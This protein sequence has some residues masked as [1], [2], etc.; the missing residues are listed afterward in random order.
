MSHPKSTIADGTRA[1]K[2]DRHISAARRSF[3]HGEMHL[4]DP[5][6]LNLCQRFE[7]MIMRATLFFCDLDPFLIYKGNYKYA[8]Q[9][10]YNFHLRS[11][12]RLKPTYSDKVRG[13]LR[14]P[15]QL[16]LCY[17]TI[18]F[19]AVC[20]IQTISCILIKRL[21]NHNKLSNTFQAN[22]TEI[23]AM[24]STADSYKMSIEQVNELGSILGNPY[25]ILVEASLLFQTTLSIAIFHGFIMIPHNFRIIPMDAPN[26]RFMLDP[27]REIRRIDMILEQQIERILIESSNNRLVMAQLRQ[28]PILRPSTLNAEWYNII[29]WIM[30]SFSLGALEGTLLHEFVSYPLMFWYV[31]KDRCKTA[32]LIGERCDI[33]SIFTW[34]E[35]IAIIELFIGQLPTIV[36]WSSLMVIIA[37]N[38]VSQVWL[39]LNIEQE[40]TKCLGVIRDENI[41]F[42]RFHQSS[43]TTQKTGRL[44]PYQY[45]ITRIASSPR[46]HLEKRKEFRSF[47]G[48]KNREDD[49]LEIL[50]Q[51]YIK[52][53]VSIDEMRRTAFFLKQCFES[54]I[55]LVGCLVLVVSLINNITTNF[56][57]SLIIMIV[58]FLTYCVTNLVLFLSAFA[59]SLTIKQEKIAWSILA[60]LSIY[61][62]NNYEAIN[63]MGANRILFDLIAT[64]W[65]RYIQ[66]HNLSD[67]K[68]TVLPHGLSI[69]YGTVLTLNF[70]LLSLA[71]VSRLNF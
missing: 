68:N 12:L 31:V 70:S 2:L 69:S 47:K 20:V 30:F 26:L 65:Y 17:L 19:L 14:K 57:A 9:A 55:V 6:Q 44:I 25:S 61:R 11:N 21:N 7:R 16:I 4:M 15:I 5:D 42:R 59:F 1:Y 24:M 45:L 58:L 46:K 54:L 60:E 33:S 43:N 29:Y 38:L 67:R 34:Q 52:L 39:A 37:V 27:L 62:A 51:T 66:S 32:N 3:K 28:M 56:G 53:V 49:I 71:Q 8:T 22:Q 40:L 10:K 41:R 63:Q 23:V 50:L 64:K 18:K 48:M 36:Y 13:S 35:M